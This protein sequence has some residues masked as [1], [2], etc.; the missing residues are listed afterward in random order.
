MGSALTLM[1]VLS[2]SFLLVRLAAT[3]LRLTGLPEPVARFQA[4]S[5]YTGTGF[6][7]LEAETIVNY[8]IRRKVVSLAMIVGNLGLVTVLATLVISFV[9]VDE[10]ASAYLT[11]LAWLAAGLAALWFLL[12]NPM[13]DRAM[14][15]ALS[16]LL[17]ATTTL[18]QR[19]FAPLLQVADGVS[20][21]EHRA[22]S[23]WI[24]D[25]PAL[26]A[27]DLARHGLEVLAVHRED[28]K[29]V[30]RPDAAF[31]LRDGD[32]LVLFGTDAGHESLEDARNVP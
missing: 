16:R 27:L 30:I 21:A 18:G 29:V 13:A 25:G 5:A 3:V 24:S 31:E 14:C 32:A 1:V 10:T 12:L 2:L 7:T 8:P 15:H 23:G 20:V 19:R 6:T 26:A 17:T 22:Q 28:G 9:R 11:Q 4:L